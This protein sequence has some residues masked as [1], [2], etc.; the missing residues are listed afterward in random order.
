MALCYKKKHS[1]NIELLATETYKVDLNQLVHFHQFFLSYYE[2]W[3]PK[4]F[5]MNVASMS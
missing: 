1:G 4:K 2:K 5:P 3:S